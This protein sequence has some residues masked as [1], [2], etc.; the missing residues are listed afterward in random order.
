MKI[1]VAAYQTHRHPQEICENF[2][3]ALDTYV[4]LN[5]WDSHVRCVPSGDKAGHVLHLA[6]GDTCDISA[7]KFKGWEAWGRDPAPSTQNPLC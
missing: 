2:S 3:D 1:A 4:L 7:V 6:C 5:R